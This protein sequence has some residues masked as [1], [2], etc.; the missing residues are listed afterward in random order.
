MF[1]KNCEHEMSENKSDG[2]SLLLL[3][4][5]MYYHIIEYNDP[6]CSTAS[7]SLLSRDYGVTESWIDR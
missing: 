7:L 1:I 4:L 5:L 3:L 6:L 2:L